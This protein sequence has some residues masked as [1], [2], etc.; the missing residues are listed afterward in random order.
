M[1]NGAQAKWVRNFMVFPNTRCNRYG[2]ALVIDVFRGF[3]VECR[4]ESTDFS[5]TSWRL[6]SV[7]RRKFYS[8]EAAKRAAI[9]RELEAWQLEKLRSEVA[10]AV[11]AVLHK[12]TKLTSPVAGLSKSSTAATSSSSTQKGLL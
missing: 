12:S 7:S 5:D 4:F 11:L 9:K 2:Y 3:T 6:S 10:I 8:L 1:C